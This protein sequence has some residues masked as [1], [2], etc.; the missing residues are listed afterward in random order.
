MKIITLSGLA[1]SG[2]STIGKLLAQELNWNFVSIGNYSRDYA[3]RNYNL[4]I[5]EFQDYLKSHPELDI[6]ID[7]YFSEK[8]NESS[9]IIVDYRLGYF[10]IKN[11]FHVYL[12]VSENEAVKR[13]LK[14]KRVDEF[15][16]IDTETIKKEMNKRNQL[17]RSRFIETY[18]TDFMDESNY[19]LVINT[20]KYFDFKDIV[21]LIITEIK[22]N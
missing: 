16:T 7:K 4:G 10:F 21:K 15:K 17:M 12:H 8:V 3:K 22:N 1:A 6:K 9:N 19:D 2:K 14:A 20:D 11:A 13:L 18:S 5:N